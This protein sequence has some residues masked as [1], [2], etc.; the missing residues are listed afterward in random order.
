[1]EAMKHTINFEVKMPIPGI[2]YSNMATSITI[3]GEGEHEDLQEYAFKC[4]ESQLVKLASEMK[5]VSFNV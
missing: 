4:L 1:V 3:E 2:A 5:E